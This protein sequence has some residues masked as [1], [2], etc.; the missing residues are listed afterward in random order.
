M[1]RKRKKRRIKGGKGE[2][3]EQG[4]VKVLGEVDYRLGEGRSS[5][6]ASEVG[7]KVARRGKGEKSL[8]GGRL[9][10]TVEEG[11]THNTVCYG[12]ASMGAPIGK[13]RGQVES[14]REGRKPRRETKSRKKGGSVRQR[15][16][17]VSTKRGEYR[18]SKWVRDGRGKSGRVEGSIKGRRV[19]RGAVSYVKEGKAGKERES[20]VGQWKG[21]G[22]EG[23]GKREGRHKRAV[24]NRMNR[25]GVKKAQ[26][27][28]GKKKGSKESGRQ[29]KKVKK[30]RKAREE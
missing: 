5:K 24:G 28:V 17:G 26:G 30:R 21:L 14:Y 15:P 3:M 16:R 19:E 27:L 13:G 8:A 25:R 1:V 22:R 20:Y 29:R 4:R 11:G 10:R 12:K 6:R 2:V 18:V 7:K 23:V 9:E